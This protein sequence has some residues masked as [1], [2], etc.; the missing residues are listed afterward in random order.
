MRD[1]GAMVTP[2]AVGLD[3]DL[4]GVGSRLQ[5]AV[6]DGLIQGGFVLVVLLGLA[7]GDAS[8]DVA[9]I[10]LL[11]SV[12]VAIWIYPIVFEAAWAG[13][14]P[15]KRVAKIRV[16]GTDGQPVR[17]PGVLVRNLLRIV[18][19]LPGVYAVGLVLILFTRRAQRLGDL[20]GGTV[21]VHEPVGAA[22]EALLLPP[23]EREERLARSIDVAG[24]SPREY[25]VARSFLIR[26]DSMTPAARAR[27]AGE[28]ASRLRERV[29]A[30]ASASAEEVVEAVVRAFRGG[31]G[32]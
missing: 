29:G 22:P 8:S 15:G 16:R 20:A 1:P 18:D 12:F 13:Q 25:A 10:T 11:I 7:A 24:I 27:V 5:A 31:A 4:A 19:L 6:I 17:F 26:R 32:G 3:A 23:A 14:T 9:L 2:E 30:D 21:V 28:I